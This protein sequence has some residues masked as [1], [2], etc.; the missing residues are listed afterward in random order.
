MKSKNLF[1]PGYDTVR[2][3]LDGNH[4]KHIEAA[5]AL[6]KI[7]LQ[8]KKL[9][10]CGKFINSASFDYLK[11]VKIRIGFYLFRTNISFEPA[12]LIY[13]NNYQLAGVN[14][15]TNAILAICGLLKLP[16]EDLKISRLDI[17]ANFQIGKKHIRDYTNLFFHPPYMKL[18]EEYV[19]EDYEEEKGGRGKKNGNV[20]FAKSPKGSNRSVVAYKKG[21]IMRIEARFL[22][23]VK[24][25]F[26]DTLVYHNYATALFD[27]EFYLRAMDFYIN[28]IVKKMCKEH[29]TELELILKQLTDYEEAV[30]SQKTW[31]YEPVLPGRKQK[32]A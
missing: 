12:S 3:Y 6:H 15:V 7:K 18:Q 24:Q 25:S 5:L 23:K 13:G 21:D 14:E 20:Y 27:E 1:Q 32:A 17:T 9:S 16:I 8:I 30:L 29:P 11:N 4:F 19:Y 28:K 31:S 26:K 2:V 10:P 22:K